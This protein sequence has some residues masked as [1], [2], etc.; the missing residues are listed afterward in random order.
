MLGCM[1]YPYGCIHHGHYFLLP[2][3]PFI[4]AVDEFERARLCTLSICV[5]LLSFFHFDAT[6]ECR[7]KG[8]ASPK[9][10]RQSFL[11][12]TMGVTIVITLFST[13]VL[14]GSS[15]IL[16]FYHNFQCTE[17]CEVKLSCYYCSNTF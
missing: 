3:D 8:M 7:K 15:T 9:S 12:W 2:F 16:D 17:K 11:P 1:P 5:V 14:R 6:R 13:T 4:A 10:S